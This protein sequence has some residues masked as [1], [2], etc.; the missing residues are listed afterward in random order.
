MRGLLRGNENNV[1]RRNPRSTSTHLALTLKQCKKFCSSAHGTRV[2][3]YCTQKNMGLLK[4][5]IVH[6]LSAAMMSAV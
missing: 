3:R 2:A 4:P 6:S 5:T 1:R